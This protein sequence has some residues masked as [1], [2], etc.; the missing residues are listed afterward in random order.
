MARLGGLSL[1]SIFNMTRMSGSKRV[2]YGCGIDH[3]VVDMSS[4]AL[5]PSLNIYNVSKY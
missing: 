3:R 1:N 2:R 4:S 5:R